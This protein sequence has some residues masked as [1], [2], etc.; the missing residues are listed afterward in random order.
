[1]RYLLALALLVAYGCASAP[2]AASDAKPPGSLRV[3]CRCECS[4]PIAAAD[5]KGFLDRFLASQLEAA[6][7]TFELMRQRWRCPRSG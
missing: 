6:G 3:P 5:V 7:C 4:V 1:M 2:P